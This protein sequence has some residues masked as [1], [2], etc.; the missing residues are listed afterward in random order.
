LAKKDRHRITLMVKAGKIPEITKSYKQAIE[1]WR[2]DPPI[3]RKF[4]E[5]LP[6]GYLP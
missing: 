6:S 4:L 2:D 1:R 3:P 5:R